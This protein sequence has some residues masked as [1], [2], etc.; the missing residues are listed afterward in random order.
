MTNLTD[1]E[2]TKSHN[3]NDLTENE[4][5]RFLTWLNANYDIVSAANTTIYELTDRLARCA[6]VW[7]DN[8]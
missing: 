1:T 2:R 4:V 6:N 7:E 3:R 5:R 8:Q